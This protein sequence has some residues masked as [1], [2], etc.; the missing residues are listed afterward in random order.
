MTRE[1]WQNTEKKI[2]PNYAGSIF[3]A[4]DLSDKLCPACNAHLSKSDICLNACHL[5]TDGRQ[6]FQGALTGQAKS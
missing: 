1:E 3:E 5:G 2:D 4:M 6:R